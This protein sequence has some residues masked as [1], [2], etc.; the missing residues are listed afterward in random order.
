MFLLP[1]PIPFFKKTGIILF[2]LTFGVAR[3]QTFDARLLKAINS[4]HTKYDKIWFGFTHSAT[5]IAIL[6]PL[7][8]YGMGHYHYLPNGKSNAYAMAGSL[9]INSI[10]TVSLKYAIHRER[11]FVAEKD[12]YKKTDVGPYSFPSGH[13]STVFATATSITL[14]YPKWYVAAPAFAWASAVGYSRMHL[15]VHYPSDVLAGAILGS[16]SSFMAFKLNQKFIK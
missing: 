6:A 2:L 13:T 16:L 10:L 11:P 5:P 12:I 15:G 14:A 4:E 7:T 3:A 9:A 8:M 1:K